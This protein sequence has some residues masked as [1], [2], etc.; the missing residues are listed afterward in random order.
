MS[1]HI[2]V[3]DGKRLVGQVAKFSCTK[4][5]YLVGN[6]SRTCLSNGR[7]TG[8]NPLCKPVDCERP[9]EVENGRV[10]VINDVTTYGGSAE[11]HCVPNY[12]RIGP[13]L[14]KCMEV[15]YPGH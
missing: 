6:D 1:E 12:N 9:N 15:R 13:Y 2:V 10:I 4:G 14:R 11:Y 3:N 7:W 5:R 8:K